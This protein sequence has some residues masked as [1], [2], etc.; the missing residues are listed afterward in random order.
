[1]LM[2]LLSLRFIFSTIGGVGALLLPLMLVLLVF[3]LL[4]ML[5][6]ATLLL[7]LLLIA[8]G[9]TKLVFGV[10]DCDI[11]LMGDEAEDVTK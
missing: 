2:P 4:E 11:L 1:M 8:V 5:M 9:L 10:N 7:L 3:M 6:L